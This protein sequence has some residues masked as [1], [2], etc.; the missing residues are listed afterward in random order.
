MDIY[1]AD[2]KKIAHLLH[3]MPEVKDGDVI[4]VELGKQFGQTLEER[5]A[6]ADTIRRAAN[7]RAEVIVVDESTT[8]EATDPR[9]IRARRA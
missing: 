1:T 3:Y 8:I 5:T 7:N 9:E 4:L 6:I 2:G